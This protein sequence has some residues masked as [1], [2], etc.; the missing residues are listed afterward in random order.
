MKIINTILRSII[1]I[2]LIFNYLHVDAQQTPNQLLRHVQLKMLAVQDYSVQANIRADIPLIKILPVN[3]TIYFEQPDK[4][5]IES[6]RISILPKQGFS[7]LAKIIRDST[8][9]TAVLTG[10]ERIGTMQT[11]QVSVIPSVD[12]GDLVLAKFW[13]DTSNSL[14]IKS[15]LTTRSSGT[16]SIE[17]FYGSQKAYGLP[18]RMVFTVDVKKFKI[19]KALATDLQTSS[20]VQERK[21]KSPNKGI[22]EINLTNYKINT[23]LKQLSTW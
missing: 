13:I 22:I 5:K 19:P 23:G 10:F 1:I 20:T 4:L 8:S 11:Q 14:I 3:A 15:Q 9:F 12:L 17:Y 6:K 16:L 18:D 21:D 2:M 7:D